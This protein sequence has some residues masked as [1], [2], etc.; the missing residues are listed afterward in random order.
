MRAP[1]ERIRK[2]INKLMKK[3]GLI[4]NP[5]AGLGGRAGFKGSDNRENQMKALRL[6]YEELSNQRAR[7]C[8]KHIK[9]ISGYKIFA[10]KGK[11]G[12]DLLENLG[13]EYCMVDIKNEITTRADTIRCIQIFKQ[14]KIDLIV[15]CGGDGTARDVWD[16][17]KGKGLFLGI[18][19]GVKMYSGCYAVSPYA[20]GEILKAF[21]TGRICSYELREI[22]D[23]DERMIGKPS[24]SPRLY[25]YLEVVSEG[26]KIQFPK[27]VS[28]GNFN[29]TELLAE[30]IVS[31]MDD[32]TLYIIGPGST[33]QKIKELSCGQGTLLGVD[34]IKKGKIIRKDADEKSLLELAGKSGKTE[35]IVTCIGGAGFIFGR[36]N[37][38]ISPE[39]IK[40][41][42]REH[43]QLAVTKSKLS[44]LNRRPMLVDT[45]NIL[46]DKYLCGYYRIYF[47]RHESAVYRVDVC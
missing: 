12:G 33:T 43:I 39:V 21:L 2:S 1:L 23:I 40:Q 19:A 30:Y 8:L 41:V 20:A 14:E 18:P 6:G 37:Q 25:G 11:M 26:G 46:V 36:G 15:F 29:E 47:S 27:S 5:A 3:I 22:M 32:S 31:Q 7:E 34:V 13:M 28:S 35:I 17:C 9:E 10:P 38:Q 44:G 24:V 16:A 42:S 4:V 45:G